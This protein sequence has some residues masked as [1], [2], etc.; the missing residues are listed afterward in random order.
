MIIIWMLI[1]C[2]LVCIKLTFVINCA[3]WFLNQFNYQCNRS[4]RK[5]NTTSLKKSK[6]GYKRKQYWVSIQVSLSVFVFQSSHLYCDIS[7]QNNVCCFYLI[8]FC[9]HYPKQGVRWEIL[10][11]AR[12]LSYYACLLFSPFHFLFIWFRILMYISYIF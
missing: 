9:H 6:Y 2:F 1:W 12:F 3:Y 11:S 5:L 4:I 10:S 7:I 8:H